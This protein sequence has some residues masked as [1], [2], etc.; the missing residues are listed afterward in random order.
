[1]QKEFHKENFDFS[2]DIRVRYS[3]TDPQGIVFNANYLNYFDVAITEY[4]RFKGYNYSDYVKKN[5]TDF[6]VIHASVDYRSPA[7]PD[8]VISVFVRG[9]Y[10]GARIF[11]TLAIY[12]KDEVLVSA[13]LIYAAVDTGSGRPKI[14]DQ[15]I[16][17]ELSLSRSE[18]K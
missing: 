3:E 5:T 17:D 18:K 2:F 6:H 11:W 15:K 10:S 12:R 4:F 1:M 9:N 7:R 13:E 14:I 8:D 16:A